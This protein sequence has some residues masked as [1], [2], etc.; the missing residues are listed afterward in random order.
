MIK[1]TLCNYNHAYIF[2][3]CNITVPSMTGTG[4]PTI[5]ANK[6]TI[7]ESCAP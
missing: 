5:N 3:K 6:K 1:S 2:V 7:L 4:A